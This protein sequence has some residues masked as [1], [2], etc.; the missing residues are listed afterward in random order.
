MFGVSQ[1]TLWKK[2]S[3]EQLVREWR[4][5][6][7]GV[8]TDIRRTYFFSYELFESVLLECLERFSL[9]TLRKVYAYTDSMVSPRY[10]SSYVRFF[11][12][13]FFSYIYS[14][15]RVGE[16]SCSNSLYSWLIDYSIIRGSSGEIS[17]PSCKNRFTL[18]TLYVAYACFDSQISRWGSLNNVV[19]IDSEL[20]RCV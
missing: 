17:R 16:V 9:H 18:S 15:L 5:S 12:P 11:H 6:L 8:L 10:S 20:R 1:L 4:I 2:L 3:L 13:I 14:A 7:Y 19:V